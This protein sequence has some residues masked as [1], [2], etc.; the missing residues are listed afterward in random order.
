IPDLGSSI[1][2]AGDDAHATWRHGH[3]LANKGKCLL[4][5]YRIPDSDSIIPTA[6]NMGFFAQ[7]TQKVYLGDFRLSALP[8]ITCFSSARVTTMGILISLCCVAN[9][10]TE[11]T[12]GY[13]EAESVTKT[14]RIDVF[15]DLCQLIEG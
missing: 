12:G 3:V 1:R 10:F 5:C 6:S 11:N 15:R 4:S 9:R 8:E 7:R 14:W 13:K 2:T